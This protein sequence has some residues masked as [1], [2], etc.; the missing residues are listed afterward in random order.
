MRRL[1]PESSA[2]ETTKRGSVGDDPQFRLI[3][4]PERVGAPFL[5]FHHK[6]APPFAGFQR[7]GLEIVVQKFLVS[8]VGIEI[9]PTVLEKQRR[10]S[11]N[12]APL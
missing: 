5:S 3:D 2:S 4:A 9:Q 10:G 6:V 12:L 7:V 1:T 8:A 11:P